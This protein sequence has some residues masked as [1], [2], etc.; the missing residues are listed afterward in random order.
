MINTYL[1]LSNIYDDANKKCYILGCGPSLYHYIYKNIIITNND[2]VISVNSSI[3]CFDKLNNKK[4]I[5]WISNDALCR[6]WSWWKNVKK[7]QGYK[8]V[9]NSWLKYKNELNDFLFFPPRPTKESI[10]NDSDEGLAYCS[11]V[12]SAIDLAIQM[13]VRDIY[14][15]GVDHQ[16]DRNNKHHFWEYLPNRPTYTRPAQ[17]PWRQQLEVFKF[18]EQSYEAL[19]Q[20]AIRKNVNIYNVINEGSK[21]NVFKKI[22]L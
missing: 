4:D 9:R 14:L 19:N 13:G 22:Q 3:L 1:K 20:F 17:G 5:F 12:P 15:L 16:K 2:I 18:A 10:I 11:S 7:F 6:R 8:I 21:L